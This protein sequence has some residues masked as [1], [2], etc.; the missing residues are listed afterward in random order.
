MTEP[1]RAGR[2]DLAHNIIDFARLLRTND[3][4][5][6]PS[7]VQDALRATG[8]IDLGDREEFYLTLRTVFLVDPARRP[9]F[10]ELFAR[11]W[12]AWSDELAPLRQNQVQTLATTSGEQ[13]PE[14]VSGESYSP[15]EVLV[16]K[17]FSDFSPDELA[18]VGRACVAIARRVAMRKSR[19]YRPTHKGGRI[20]PRR[21]LRRSLQYG[22]TVLDLARL[23]RKIRK[24]RIVLICDVSRSMEQYS[25]FLLQFIHSMQNVIGRIE[26][27]VFSTAL[28]R[29]TL[30]FK[31]ADI[32]TAVEDLAQEIPD[33]S[34][35]TR[36]GE[37]LKT[38]NEHYARRM[39]DKRTVVVILSDGLDTGQTEV[40][41]EQMTELQTRAGRVIWLNP[42]LGKD[43]YQPLAR[44]MLAALP[45]VD[46]FAPA[47]NLAS[48]QQ[49]ATALSQ[50]S[51][52]RSS[53]EPVAAP[54][55]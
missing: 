28:H 41:D 8:V 50:R 53:S 23:E 1:A 26:S 55:P 39:V 10:D 21:S 38:F 29:V 22:G 4:L 27:F 9:E 33:W 47:H 6:S 19:R 7:E 24:P 18:Q 37:S 34:G 48:L 13:P 12:G 20:D 46:V 32:M 3:F 17:D 25:V 52:P 2:S 35:G 54:P 44:G 16:E 31:H 15:T 14:Q 11:F 43:D 30:Y 51:A 36:I 45:H 40:L 42:L 49:L 5:A